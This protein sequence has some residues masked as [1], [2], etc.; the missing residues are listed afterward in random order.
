LTNDTTRLLG[1]D[2]VEVASV[3]L[4]ELDNPLLALVT[5]AETVRYCPECG[6]VS[7]YPHS[8]V[9]TRPR[10]LP[11]AG[12]PTVLTW[13]KRRWRCFNPVCARATFT[14]HIPQI[15]PRHRLTARLREA[16]SAAV[17][18]GGRTV[19]HSARDHH[20]SWPIVNAAVLAHAE[21]ALPAADPQ[22][23]ALGIDE[24]RRG[25]AKCR[26]DEKTGT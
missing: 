23:E 19:E 24:I 3:E 22:V 2:G 20:L 21:A 9:R 17:G 4:D 25:K 15:P 13:I 14:E 1:L 6:Q 26:W 7:Q 11:V 12:R 8:W 16:A 10:D 18:D 5:A